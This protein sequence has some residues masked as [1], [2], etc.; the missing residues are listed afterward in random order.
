[1]N[2]YCRRPT[3]TYKVGIMSNQPKGMNKNLSHTVKRKCIVL[4]EY[5]DLARKG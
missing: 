2:Q 1:M 5:I 4:A 3:G